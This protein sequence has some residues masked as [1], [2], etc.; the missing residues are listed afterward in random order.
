MAEAQPK[1]IFLV[2]EDWFFRS[3]FLGRARAAKAAGYEVVVAARFGADRGWIDDEGFRAVHLNFNRAGLNP[4]AE[5]ATVRAIRGLYRTE[6]PALVHHVALKPI[7]YGT[8]AGLSCGMRRIV[9]APVGLGFVFTSQSLKARLLAP[10]VKL[11]MRAMLNPRGS[12]VVFENGDDRDHVV[13]SGVVAAGAAVLIRGAGVDVEEVRPT[14]E[15]GGRL[16]VLMLTRMLADK[17]VREFVEAARQIRRGA[18]PDAR[19]LLVGEP[20]LANPSTLTEVE[21]RGW[22]DEG[23]VEWLGFRSDVPALLAASH[24]VVLPSYR[25][26]LPKA[27]LE[28]MA[29]GR[30]V[31]ATDVPGCRDVVRHGD[32]GLLV[33]A[34]DARSLAQAIGVLLADKPMR[35]RMGARGRL[36]AEQEFSADIV[37]ARTLALYE[38]MLR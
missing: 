26:G 36:K 20:D 17:G 27:L 35:L 32:N 33:P 8:A 3:H 28:A 11:A 21:L 19:F 6:K 37:N 14:P 16:T 12:R 4:L 24:V 9:N 38:S 34:R 25:E 1:L 5:L 10:M 2:T 13:R 30:P 18:H 15:P 23:I 31:V 7:F 29:A 22:H